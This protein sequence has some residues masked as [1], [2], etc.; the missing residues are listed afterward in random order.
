VTDG[1]GVARVGLEREGSVFDDER[2]VPVEGEVTRAEFPRV[3]KRRSRCEFCL[4]LVGVADVVR[5]VTLGDVFE[6][7]RLV[8]VDLPRPVEN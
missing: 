2:A 4:H 8:G 1:D 6:R 3:R 5:R 7:Q